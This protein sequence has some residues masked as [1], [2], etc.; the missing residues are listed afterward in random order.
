MALDSITIA[1][2]T[3]QLE[4]QRIRFG[5]EIAARQ[6]E[7]QRLEDC[8]ARAD[9]AAKDLKT[10]KWS[11]RVENKAL[12]DRLNAF[13]HGVDASHIKLLHDVRRSISRLIHKFVSEAI[14]RQAADRL[15]DS[16]A[17]VSGEMDPDDDEVI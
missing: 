15:D 16:D 6:R 7:M 5:E 3:A 4:E 10:D 2:L 13:E 8:L 17:E 1:N 9:E 12:R 11:L 14:R